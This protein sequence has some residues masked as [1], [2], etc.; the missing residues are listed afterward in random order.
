MYIMAR[1]IK[2]TG[3]KVLLSGEGADEALGGYL[4]FHKAPNP[5]E[6]FHETVRKVIRLHQWDVLRANK[7]MAAWGL[8]ARVPL[9]DKKFLEVV[10]NVDPQYK[11]CDMTVKPDGVHP[12]MEKY[13]LR[14]AFDLPGDQAYLPE[15][16]LWRQKE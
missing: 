1:R 9:L 15:D 3:I 14:K 6:F 10:M 16:V 13:I 11:M 12:K 2:P 7:S 4:Y 8:E 5:A